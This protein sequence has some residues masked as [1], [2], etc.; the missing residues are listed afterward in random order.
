MANK[1][2]LQGTASSVGKSLLTAALCRIFKQDG[3]NVAPFKSQNMAL[4]SFV[5]SEGK[6]IG[7]AQ[8]V[9]AEAAMVEPMVEM[10][11]ILLKP[12]SDVGCQV[13]LNGVVYKNMTADVYHNNKAELRDE[14]SK[15]F[16]KLDSSFDVVVIEGAGSPAE[17]NLRENDL[18]NMGLAELID[19]PVILVGDIDRGGVFA[20][21]YG[22]IM[23]MTEQERERIKGFIINKFRGDI[24]LLKP[25]I[26]ML[27]ELVNKP[28]LGVIPYMKLNI[29]D[30]DSVTDR[31]SSKF[32]GDINI[33]VIRT[34]YISNFSDFTPLEIEEGVNVIYVTNREQLDNADLIILPG[35]KNTI[36]DIEFVFNSGI[37]K[38]IYK[39]HRE[40]VPII[41]ICGGYQML[42]QQ[43]EDP[44]HIES[45]IERIN[46]LCLLDA[47]TVIK[48]KKQ[49]KQV[50][51]KLVTELNSFNVNK[52][53]FVTGYEIHMGETELFSD[54]H[55][56]FELEDGRLDGA[57]NKSGNVFGTY[58]HGIFEN[59]DL[60]RSIIKALKDKKGIAEDSEQLSYKELKDNEYNKLAQAVRDNADLDKI[61][62]IM[63]LINE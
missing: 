21:I 52:N 7:R 43:V 39:K 9:Q 54:S 58:L 46:G 30:E 51:G 25:G 28:C 42:G 53:T 32:I 26:K 11:P 13:I 12:T 31:F 48:E 8:A 14:I 63:G 6:E 3:Y 2:M 1:I 23:L 62:M 59:D 40:G 57:I 27:E 35:S 29:D 34:P 17:I 55:H 24:E 22:T 10:N 19:S 4:N 44:N 61:R 47:K 33:A 36:R 38:A 20:S 41:G 5:T 50:T 60:R 56:V 18:V 15:A 49:T 16:D 45:S 37:D